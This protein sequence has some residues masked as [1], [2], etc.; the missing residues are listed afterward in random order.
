VTFRTTYG[1]EG[2]L[3]VLPPQVDNFVDN[4]AWRD[5]ARAGPDAVAVAA[6]KGSMKKVN[7]FNDL[8]H[9]PVACKAI[10]VCAANAGAAVEL[11]R[12]ARRRSR[13]G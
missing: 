13:D 5:R 1:F 3:H 8:P 2:I 11:S 12:P 7:E 10:V 4:S 9:K 6:S